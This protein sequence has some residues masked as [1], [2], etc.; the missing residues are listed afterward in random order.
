MSSWLQPYGLQSDRLLCPPLFPGVCQIHVYWVDDSIQLSHP[1]QLPSFA[2]NLSQH[3][4][5]I[6]W[7]GSSRQ[8]FKVLELQLQHQSS[9]EYSGLISFRIDRFD[10]LGVQGTI[11]NLLQ[12]HNLKTLILQHATFFMVQLSNAYITTRKNTDLTIWIFVGKAKSLLFSMLSRFVI[13]FYPRSKCILILWLQS[14]SPV[15][16]EPKKIKSV[17]L[18]LFF[19]LFAWVMGPDAVIFI[20][21]MLSF[22]SAFSLS[23]FTLNK[24]LFSSASL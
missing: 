17:L 6:Q 9:N 1:L 21:W 10:F 2:F 19:H 23:P 22:K 20:F 5:L 11:K 18:P 14:L 15:T 7:V 8:V 4:G 3:Q 24:R 16:L 13:A 12:Y